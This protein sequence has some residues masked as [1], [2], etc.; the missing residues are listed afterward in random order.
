MRGI[1]DALH[2]QAHAAHYFGFLVK[3]T[4]GPLV[5]PCN[6]GILLALGRN[7]VSTRRGS[8]IYR[9]D[10]RDAVYTGFDLGAERKQRN[11]ETG[12]DEGAACLPGVSTQDEHHWNR[13]GGSGGSTERDGERGPGWWADIPYWRTRRWMRPGTGGSKLPREK[14]R[15]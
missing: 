11:F 12:K 8:S 14:A 10:P 2:F 7:C 6:S 13:K 1:M 3:V 15:E 9:I 4:L 5:A